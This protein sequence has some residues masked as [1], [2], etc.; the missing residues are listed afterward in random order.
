MRVRRERDDG[1]LDALRLRR[2][3]RG[4]RSFRARAATAACPLISIGS[5]SRKPIGRSPNSGWSSRRIAVSRPTRP[6]PTMIVVAA[7]RELGSPPSDDEVG[8]SACRPRAEPSPGARGAS[9]GYTLGSSADRSASIARIAIAAT[10]V[11]VNVTRRSSSASSLSRFAY[12]CQPA[13]RPTTTTSNRTAAGRRSPAASSSE[14]QHV[15]QRRASRRPRAARASS[16]GA[17]ASARE[18]ELAAAGERRPGRPRRRR[19]R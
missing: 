3:E 5:A 15:R 14:E 6:A 17:A 13:T 9:A 12:P 18:P 19:G 2:R 10:A 16:T 8:A 4:S 1:A 7:V 11:D